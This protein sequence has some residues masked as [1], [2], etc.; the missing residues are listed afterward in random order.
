MDLLSILVMLLVLYVLAFTGSTIFDRFGV[1]GLIGQIVVGII[2]ANIFWDG[3]NFAASSI[4]SEGSFLGLFDIELASGTV[5]GSEN[6]NT[7]RLI[8]ELGAIFLLFSVGLETKASE[9]KRVGKPALIVALLGV[10]I[11]FALGMT[12]IFYDQNPTHALYMA[13]AMVATSVGVTAKVLSDLRVTDTKEGRI[14]LGAAIIDDVL[15]MMVLAVVSGMSSPGEG[16][17]GIIVAIIIAVVFVLVVFVFCDKCIPRMDSWYCDREGCRPVRVSKFQVDKLMFAIALCLFMATISEFLG[18]AAI[19]GAFLAGMM[20]ADFSERWRLKPKV[21]ALTRFFLPLFFL[22]V[23]MQIQTSSLMNVSVL[24]L[25]TYVIILAV[26]SKYVGGYIGVRMADKN[27]DKDSASI[28]GI[29]MIPRAEVGLIIASIGFA[30]GYL[31]ADMNAAIV[32]MSVITTIIAPPL[33]KR[34][35]KKKYPDSTKTLPDSY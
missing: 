31:T 25:S 30:G 23:G 9:L 18:L 27:I 28:V 6:Y 13:A 16:L 21:D 29:G 5:G 15:G 17:M 33:L 10:V 4:F 22:N 12:V 8:A 11:P 26:I 32:L 1:P 3:S 7:L 14:I 2:I 35:F 34:G 20:L 19:I 24:A